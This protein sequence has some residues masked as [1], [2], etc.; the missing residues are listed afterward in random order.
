MTKFLRVMAA[1]AAMASLSSAA[2][3]VDDTASATVGLVVQPASYCS[4]LSLATQL[5][6][7]TIVNA[8]NTITQKDFT[9]TSGDVT[10]TVALA[11]VSLASANGGLSNSGPGASATPVGGFIDKLHYTAIATWSA[12]AGTFAT[13][14][15]SS[16]STATSAGS[17]GP[18]TGG[19]NL[20]VTP[21]D[22]GTGIKLKG[23]T[24]YTDT[25][26]VKVGPSA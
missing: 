12:G 17:A 14:V 3:A 11:K 4:G 21:A 8:D 15:T 13:L 26:T 25:L 10:C 20:K 6:M 16:G 9:L 24:A 7:S 22:P 18:A 5:N 19:F 23:G 2:H 1:A